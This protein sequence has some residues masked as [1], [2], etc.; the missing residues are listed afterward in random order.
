YVCD[1]KRDSG[2]TRLPIGKPVPGARLYVLDSGGTIQP[3]GVAGELYIAGT[4]VARGYLNRP[5][6]TEERF[7][8]DPFYPGER[9]YQT[10]DIARWTEDGLVEWLGRSDGQV[11]VRGYRIEPGEIE[12]AIRR[13]DGI[14]EAAVTARTEHGETALYA[15]IEGR[16]SDDVRAELATRLP[17]YM[18]PA[19]F[20]EMTEW[21]VTPSGKLDRRALPAPGGA[22][23]RRAY[24][25]PRNVT[26]MKLCGLWEEVLKNGPVGIRDHFFER[27]GHSLKATALVSRIAKEFGVQVPLQDIFARPTVEELASVIQDL[28]ESPYEA[29]QPAQKQDTYPVSSAQKRMYV[30]QQLEDGGVGYN[31]P[32][33]LELTGPLDRGRLE[34]TFRQL[35][36]RHES[37]RTSFETGPDGEPVQRIHDSVP[38]QLDEAESADAFV[39]P[40][41]LE[42]A[43]LFRAALVKESDE[44]HLLLT[45]M[46]HIISDGV[47]VNTLI[48][49]FGELYAGR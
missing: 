5:E 41:C 33:V 22:A 10:G 12:A 31:M 13:I 25:A 39:R 15:Y 47:S 49:E 38:F 37:L 48:K 19:Q 6:L 32:A 36:E 44:H 3:A 43:P 20:I 26:E 17:A 34:E 30:L 28:E 2:R 14:R 45:D 42:E 23:D 7:L 11:K 1:R 35:V 29:I 8:D 21:P 18:M 46:H 16:E 24:T 40:F 4:G 27:G 9:M